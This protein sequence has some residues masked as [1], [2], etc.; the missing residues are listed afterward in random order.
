M[1]AL[2]KKSV[3]VNEV[4]H[5]V[6]RGRRSDTFVTRREGGE[7]EKETLLDSES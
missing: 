2:L 4:V 3:K 7:E 5:K 6:S 1:D